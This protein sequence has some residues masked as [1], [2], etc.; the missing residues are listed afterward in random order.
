MH[1]TEKVLEKFYYN[2]IT[3]YIQEQEKIALK[4]ALNSYRSNQ[5]KKKEI[6]NVIKKRNADLKEYKKESKK[7]YKIYA[8]CKEQNEADFDAGSPPNCPE[9]Y[10]YHLLML[11]TSNAPLEHFIS[12]ERERWHIVGKDRGYAFFH[13]W[14]QYS[15]GNKG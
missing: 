2:Q 12:L 15:K 10:Y 13:I 1:I 5:N 3:I 7:I 11:L 9:E 8:E 14:Y 4:V 6:I